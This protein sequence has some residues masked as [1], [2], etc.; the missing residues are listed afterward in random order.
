MLVHEMHICGISRENWRKK[1]T[2]QNRADSVFFEDVSASA[3][4]FASG[5]GGN[6][7]ALRRKPIPI[8]RETAF[9][10]SPLRR[11]RRLSA[12]SSAALFRAALPSS[13]LFRLAFFRRPNPGR[14]TRRL[15]QTLYAAFKR[16]KGI[17]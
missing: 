12:P 1:K 6:N 13:A 15:P 4:G 7:V 3:L 5:G 10:A 2:M 8:A 16:K 11:T 14:P 17:P 9:S